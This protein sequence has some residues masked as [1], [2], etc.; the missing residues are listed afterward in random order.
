MVKATGFAL[1]SFPQF[2]SFVTSGSKYRLHHLHL[3]R[4]L[5][6]QN[7]RPFVLATTTPICSQ[8]CKLNWMGTTRKKK[9]I[10]FDVVD[11]NAI[12]PGKLMQ[13]FLFL[14][15]N[16]EEHFISKL[17][18]VWP[19]VSCLSEFPTRGSL[20]VLASYTDNLDE[21]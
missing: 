13:M 14:L 4:E 18:F 1:P 16:Q 20:V 9:V 21:V 7:L 12:A 17:H 5:R 2:F 11:E 3:I 19:Q 10:L 8:V 6:Q 15:M